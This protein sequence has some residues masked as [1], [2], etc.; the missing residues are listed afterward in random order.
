[1][2]IEYNDLAI[3][4]KQANAYRACQLFRGGWRIG[5]PRSKELRSSCFQNS[6]L[7]VRIRATLRCL[8]SRRG[9]NPV[10][11]SRVVTEPSRSTIRSASN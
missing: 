10:A 6:G 2:L 8:G 1:M 7:I 4:I 5:N 11:V 3:D 9:F